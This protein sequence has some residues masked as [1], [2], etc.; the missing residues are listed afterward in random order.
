MILRGI[1]DRSLSSQL[2]IRGFAPIKELARISKADYSYQRSLI[3]KQRIKISNFLDEEKYLFF[4]E[5]ILSYKVQYDLAKAAETPSLSPLQLLDR[6]KKF[7]SNVD[8]S[9]IRYSPK[10]YRASQDVRGSDELRMVEL[11]LDDSVL[12]N[13]IETEKHPFNRVDGNHRLSAAEHSTTDRIN[14]MIIPYCVILTES[15]FDSSVLGFNEEE[16]YHRSSKFEKVV[17]HNINTKSANLTSEE[18]LRVILEDQ[19]NFPDSEIKEKFGSDY[20]LTRKL[21]LI[22]PNESIRDALPNV[23]KAFEVGG[24]IN[25]NAVLNA[26]IGFLLDNKL[27]KSN[28]SVERLKRVIWKVNNEFYGFENL[29]DTSNPAFLIASCAIEV[30]DKHDLN[31]FIIWLAK[32]HLGQLDEVSAESLYQIY[33]S[34]HDKGPKVFVAMPYDKE[35]VHTWNE[36]FNRIADK[37]NE[38]NKGVGLTVYPIMTHDGMSRNILNEMLTQIDDCS[39]FVADVSKSNPNVT[40]EL[41]YAKQ[42]GI[43]YIIIKDSADNVDVPFD[44]EHDSRKLFRADALAGLEEEMYS[45]I[46]EILVSNYKYG[47]KES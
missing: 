6:N 5:V 9:Q 11:I 37:I 42:R 46:K 45:D 22:I 12:N 34:I 39:I 16:F 35:V 27:I 40:F 1:L 36:M 47:F 18:N 23:I 31:S 25:K 19:E 7:K 14:R 33:I 15:V 4:P 2:C 30:D 29:T 38:E 8:K 44:F 21:G 17:F 24:K 28:A 20:M 43:P 41:G 32:N 10:R 13:L 3:N 26:L